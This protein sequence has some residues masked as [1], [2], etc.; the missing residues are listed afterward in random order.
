[1][2]QIFSA[3]LTSLHSSGQSSNQ[4]AQRSPTSPTGS[5][6]HQ[7]KADRQSQN[8]GR[9]S[10]GNSG[11]PEYPGASGSGYPGASG[12]AGA[13]GYAGAA[14]GGDRGYGSSQGGARGFSSQTIP[15]DDDEDLIPPP[16]GESSR[17]ISSPFIRMLRLY[18]YITKLCL[19]CCVVYKTAMYLFY[20]MDFDLLSLTIQWILALL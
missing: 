3:D 1:M 13:P 12:Y 20:L 14:A 9:T 19:G 16:I 5:S 18:Q 11:A 15:R 2:H 17:Y 8:R 6:S 4:S 10:H 7:Y